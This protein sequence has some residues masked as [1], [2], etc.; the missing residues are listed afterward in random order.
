MLHFNVCHIDP[1]EDNPDDSTPGPSVP[2]AQNLTETTYR[3]LHPTYAKGLKTRMSKA[4]K[5][6]PKETNLDEEW[7]R[8]SI[9][10]NESI[11]NL[12]AAK[13]QLV[14]LQ[15]QHFFENR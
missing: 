8:S 7:M 14:Q 9:K 4:R 12:N 15:I 6:A 13:L 10:A 1:S 5:R 3:H 2:I 11:I